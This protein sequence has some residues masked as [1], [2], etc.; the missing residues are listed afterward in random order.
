MWRW[1][2]IIFVVVAIF[3]TS[4]TG[5]SYADDQGNTTL[6]FTDTTFAASFPCHVRLWVL[7]A[8]LLITC[9]FLWM[10]FSRGLPHHLRVFDDDGETIVD[11][12]PWTFSTKAAAFAEELGDHAWRG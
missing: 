11:P 10:G 1:W 4:P 9:V 2:L 12:N 6:P 8:V 7:L 5:R 3:S